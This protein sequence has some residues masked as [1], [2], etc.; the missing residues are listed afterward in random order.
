MFKELNIDI[1]PAKIYVDNKSTIYNAENE[2]INPRSKHI[3]I[4]YH[5]VRDLIKKGTIKLE[6]INTNGNIADGFTK[7]LNSNK[8][9]KFR[10]DLLYKFK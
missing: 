2:T 6:Y 7:Y 1:K 4:K 8:M 9:T 3:N 10:N 5:M